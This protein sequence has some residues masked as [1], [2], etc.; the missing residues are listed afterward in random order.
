MIYREGNSI[1]RRSDYLTNRKAIFRRKLFWFFVII[2]A[3][4]LLVP[5]MRAIW[6]RDYAIAT[7]PNCSII[8]P[9]SVL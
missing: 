7:S 6:V 1:C 5:V 8:A 4:V 9:T 3:A 2:V